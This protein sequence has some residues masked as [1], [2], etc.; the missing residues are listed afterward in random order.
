MIDWIYENFGGS[1]RAERVLKSGKTFYVWRLNQSKD[2]I[3]L[4][5]ML[6]PFLT[7]KKTK[8]INGLHNMIN[9]FGLKEFTLYPHNWKEG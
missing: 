1:S 6:I 5:L 7:T 8:V 9:K 4:L 2:L 3:Y